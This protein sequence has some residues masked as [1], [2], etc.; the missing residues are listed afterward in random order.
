MSMKDY[1][2]ACTSDFNN[3]RAKRLV[4]ESFVK[5]LHKRLRVKIQSYKT[6]L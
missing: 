2:L 4:Q 5:E 6:D 3:T 1:E